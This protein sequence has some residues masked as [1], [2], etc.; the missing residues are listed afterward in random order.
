MDNQRF[1]CENCGLEHNGNYGS[2]RFCSEKCA[3]SYSTKNESKELKEAKCIK[4]GKKI[5][6]DKRASIK[7]CKCE[8][9]KKEYHKP[10]DL[11]VCK[12]CGSTYYKNHGGVVMNFV[13]P[14]V[15]RVLIYL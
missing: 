6:I 5:Y 11:K 9:C 4:C 15:F 14:I 12:I 10:S 13:K 7:T 3:K 2:G 8:S 1:I